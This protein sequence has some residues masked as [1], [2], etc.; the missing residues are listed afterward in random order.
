MDEKKV[1]IY[2][3]TVCEYV[4]ACLILLHIIRSSV[5]WQRIV[6]ETFDQHDWT[7]ISEWGGILFVTLVISYDPSL[8]AKTQ[9]Y[10]KVLVYSSELPSH[11]GVCLRHVNIELL[12][13]F[14]ESRVQLC[15]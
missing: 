5:W 1:S 8:L 12:L 6:M 14:L 13:I 15:V 7:E 2:D 11:F 9:G 10:I 4:L 3:I